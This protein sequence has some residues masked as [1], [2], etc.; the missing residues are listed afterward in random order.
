[1]NPVSHSAPPAVHR[2]T[3]LEYERMVAC[4]ALDGMPVE[5]VDGFLV[6]VSPQGPQHAALVRALMLWLLPHAELL[7]VQMPLAVGEAS[8]PEPDIALVEHD[9]PSRHPSAALLV[10]EVAVT[11]RREAE[12]KA[13]LYASAGIPSY[14]VVDVPARTV[15]VHTEPAAEGYGTR[16]LLAQQDH[17]PALPPAEPLTVAQLFRRA[18]LTPA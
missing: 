7:R 10:I 4:G 8:E 6:D 13:P 3:R 15:A 18:G 14:W 5:L 11:S 2:L 17:L 1:M 9:D 16:V 12:H